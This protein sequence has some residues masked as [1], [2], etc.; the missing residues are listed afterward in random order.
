MESK[1]LAFGKIADIVGASELKFENFNSSDELVNH[2]KIQF[3]KLQDLKFVVAVDKKII[4]ESVLLENKS[5]VALLPPFS[6]G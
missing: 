5:T 4:S 1:V 3:P 6:G 2:L